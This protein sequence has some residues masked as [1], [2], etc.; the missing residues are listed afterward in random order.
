MYTCTVVYMYFQ[1]QCMYSKHSIPCDYGCFVAF[2]VVLPSLSN[3]P[4]LSLFLFCCSFFCSQHL[5]NFCTCFVFGP[6]WDRR[7]SRVVR[8]IEERLF[9]IYLLCMCTSVLSSVFSTRPSFFL[10]NN[11][12][13][14]TLRKVKHRTFKDK[15]DA[16]RAYVLRE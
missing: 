15:R 1:I 14:H 6:L 16:F 7:Y 10:N 12:K 3:F 9:Y 5:F 4:S 11:R 2:F 8:T 13:N